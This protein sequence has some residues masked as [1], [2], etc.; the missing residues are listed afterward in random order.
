MPALPPGLC[1]V[2]GASSGIGEAF[3]RRLSALGHPLLLVARREARLQAL[4]AAL[5]GEAEVLVADLSTEAGVDAV[6]EA[7][8]GRPLALLV[9]NAGA[10]ALGPFAEQ[11]PARQLAL[12]QLNCVAVVG[13]TRRLLPGMLAQGRGGVIVVS[14]VGGFLP[15]PWL[16]VY[17]ATKAFGLA[18]T[19][20]LSVELR[21]SGVHALA[22]CPGPT[23]TEFGAQA[24]VKNMTAQ[25]IYLAP[26]A[27]AQA[28]LDGLG[29]RVI[30]VPG[31]MN[32]LTVWLA[33]FVPR[34][35]V[36]VLAG[37]VGESLMG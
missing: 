5:P 25:D 30:V 24:G 17:G 1:V 29:R 37:K 11:D 27:V 4:A 20:A 12:V 15:S 7:V 10:G 14:S 36:R 23:R 3:A 16:S 18:F 33:R 9:N 28:A 13:L 26:E 22:L 31:L 8:A 6:V 32:K 21:G 35:L 19:E 2:T 34:G